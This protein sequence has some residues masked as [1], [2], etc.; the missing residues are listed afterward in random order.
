MIRMKIISESS[1]KNYRVDRATF[2]SGAFFDGELIC[3]DMIDASGGEIYLFKPFGLRIQVSLTES[4]HPTFKVLK[5][6]IKI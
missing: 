4:K 2:K 5:N 1:A 3:P 6:N